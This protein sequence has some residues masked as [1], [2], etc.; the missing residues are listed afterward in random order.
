MMPSGISDA[1]S[2]YSIKESD[3]L[4]E[5]DENEESPEY[6]AYKDALVP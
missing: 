6:C 4:S 1:E 2:H 3:M 5:S